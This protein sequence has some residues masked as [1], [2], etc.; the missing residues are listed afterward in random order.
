MRKIL[1]G[2]LIGLYAEIVNAKNKDNIGIK[3]EITDETKNMITIDGKKLIKSQI[4]IILKV[5]GKKVQVEGELLQGRP[6]ERIK[7]FGRRK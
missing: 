6:E 2:E 7:K 3:G 1:Q 4:T 5:K